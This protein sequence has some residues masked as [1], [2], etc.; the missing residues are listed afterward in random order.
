MSRAGKNIL[1][2][3]YDGLTDPLGQSQIL[4]Y[5][6]SLSKLG[7]SFTIVSFEK[8]NSGTPIFEIVA[9]D[10]R[11]HGITWV[12]LP[13]HKQPPVLSTIYDVFHLRKTVKQLHQEKNFDLVHCRSYITAL[14]G[15]WLKR[16]RGVKFI[17]DMRGFWA[18]ERVDGGIWNLTNPLYK[19]IYNFFKRK[20]LSF[21]NESDMVISLTHTAKKVIQSWDVTTEIAVIPCCVDTNLFDP[22]K[23][24]ESKKKKLQ[25]ELGITPG[26][27][28]LL[29]LG[30]WGTWYMTNEML[31]FFSLLKTKITGA[32]FIIITHNPVE[33]VNYPLQKD[34]CT[35]K[36]SR[37]NI[38]LY[39]SLASASI[40]FIKPSFSKKASSATK[41]GELLAMNIPVI[42]NPGWGDVETIHTESKVYFKDSL[43]LQNF[44]FGSAPSTRNYCLNKLSLEYGRDCYNSVYKK[45]LESKSIPERLQATSK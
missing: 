10:C 2:L 24:D 17:F 8:E 35:L 34:V 27:F 12:P 20:E 32:K 38:P 14:V 15:L 5:I 21:F 13:Y 30:S 22:E 40:C 29:Y 16:K 43:I 33:L 42:T 3:T 23:I 45:L 1:Y 36:V 39:L 25:L 9:T 11:Q 19:T 7:Y 26:D 31:D 41:M 28:V 44:E 4:P 6:F 37:E 18:D